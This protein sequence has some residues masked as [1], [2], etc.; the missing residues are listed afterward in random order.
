MPKKDIQSAND[1]IEAVTGMLGGVFE[2]MEWAEDEIKQAQRRYP[3]ATNK[4]FYAFALLKTDNELVGKELLY[5]AHC[6]E[7]LA[8]VVKDEDTRPGT[9]AEICAMMCDISQRTPLNTAAF[10]LYAR[11]WKLAGLPGDQFDDLPH[12]E[13]IAAS[14]IDDFEAESRA[15][16]AVKDRRFGIDDCGGKHHGVEVDCEFVA[17]PKGAAA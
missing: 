16:L 13:A 8:R 1:I 11:V 7:I 12:Y 9:A 3:Q 15:K 14:R 4:L 17:K 10:G 2:R 6:R 5:R